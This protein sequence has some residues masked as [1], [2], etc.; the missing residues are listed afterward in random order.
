MPKRGCTTIVSAGFS[1]ESC[2]SLQPE[3]EVLQEVRLV[4][5]HASE[6]RPVDF[7]DFSHLVD[8]SRGDAGWQSE[9]NSQ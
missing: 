5:A 2:S 4:S 1:S 6:S 9:Q 3:E 8:P 7:V